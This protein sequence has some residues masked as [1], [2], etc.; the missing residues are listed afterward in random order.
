M[1]LSRYGMEELF[2]GMTGVFF[3]QFDMKKSHKAL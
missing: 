1:E 2:P 3:M